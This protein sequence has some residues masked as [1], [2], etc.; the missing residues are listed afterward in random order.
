VDVKGKLRT[1][2]VHPADAVEWFISICNAELKHYLDCNSVR[3]LHNGVDLA[4]VDHDA[5]LADL[6]I[7]ETTQLCV[8]AHGN[9]NNST[10]LNI[11]VK[12]LTGNTYTFNDVYSSW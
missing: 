4:A 12:T 2:R 1:V 8:E 7:N 9:Y 10:M 11:T 5:T 3:V 6:N